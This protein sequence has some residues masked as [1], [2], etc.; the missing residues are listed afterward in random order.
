MGHPIMID[1]KN[2]IC[3][4]SIYVSFAFTG[5]R[6][7]NLPEQISSCRKGGVNKTRAALIQASHLFLCFLMVWVFVTS[8][9]PMTGPCILNIYQREWLIM[10]IR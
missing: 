2:L 5:V 6:S 1:S 10:F 7:R 4:K 9:F 3:F 8:I